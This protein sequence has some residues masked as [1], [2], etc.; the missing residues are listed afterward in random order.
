MWPAMLRSMRRTLTKGSSNA[1]HLQGDA[2]CRVM[3]VRRDASRRMNARAM[4]NAD[5]LSSAIGY[6]IGGKPYIKGVYG[7]KPTCEWLP[8]GTLAQAVRTWSTARLVIAPHGAG[9]TNLLFMPPGSTI[10]EIIRSDQKGRVY[11]KLAQI[12]GHYYMKCTYNL[13]DAAFRPQLVGTQRTGDNFI[14]NLPW[15]LRCLQRGFMH[16]NAQRVNSSDMASGPRY[17]DP[18][19]KDAWGRL[20]ELLGEPPLPS[21]PHPPP[22][23]LQPPP[24]PP[25]QSPLASKQTFAPDLQ[26]VQVL[27][28]H[29]RNATADFSHHTSV[30]VVDVQK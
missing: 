8:G 19:S 26:A 28:E 9:S 15:F 30:R 7:L 12:S 21:P 22:P 29:V 5:E 18:F 3:V 24:P 11:K 25:E 16:R 13:K 23:L 6:I 10:V 27:R 4:L 1:N 2:S 17:V 20:Q 14:L